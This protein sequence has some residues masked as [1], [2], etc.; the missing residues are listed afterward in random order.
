MALKTT[1]P[2]SVIRRLPR[3]YRYLSTLKQLGISR[4]S[5]KDLSH[6]MGYTSSQIRQDFFHLGRFG[7]QGYGYDVDYLFEEIGHA[8]K[9]QQR[10]SMIVIGAGHLGQALANNIAFEKLGFSLAA[11]FD[12]DSQLVSQTVRGK[13]IYHIS[14]L[15]DFVRGNSV[16]IAV[17][18]V[19]RAHA[20][21]LAEQIVALGI[22]GIWNFTSAELEVPQGVFVE[23]I[24]MS[25]SLMV[26][27]FLLE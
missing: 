18:T 24:H 22:R 6:R 7:L 14:S 27:G 9:V 15:S 10:R 17:L 20:Y 2:E 5:S 26:L 1:I 19:P 12:V 3:Y 4:I 21:D 23:N 11:L 8:L 25:D 13:E 16:D